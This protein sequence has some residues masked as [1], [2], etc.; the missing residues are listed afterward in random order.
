[1]SHLRSRQP[2]RDDD[3]KPNP[4]AFKDQQINLTPLLS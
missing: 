2:V 4:W 3:K 1:V